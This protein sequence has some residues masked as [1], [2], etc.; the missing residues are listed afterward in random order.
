MNRYNIYRTGQFDELWH[1][2][3]STGVIDSVIGE[4]QLA[5]LARFLSVDPRIFPEFEASGE[6][7]DLRWAILFTTETLRIESLV[8]GGRG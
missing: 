2:V 5:A 6:R 3:K 7:V 1:W 4:D 8:L